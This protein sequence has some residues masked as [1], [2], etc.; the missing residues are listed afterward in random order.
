MQAIDLG[1]RTPF[2]PYGFGCIGIDPNPPR[3]GEP[4]TIDMPLSNSTPEP[5]GVE[6]IEVR[7]APFGIGV[8]WQDIATL[9]PLTL[10]PD[11]AHIEHA[12]ATWTPDEPG[13]RCVRA[14]IHVAGK[15]HPQVVGRNLDIVRAGAHEDT[16]S[17]PF[18]LGNP[19]RERVPMMLRLVNAPTLAGHVRVGGRIL[20]V[21]DP[22]WLQPG[23]VVA[24]EVRLRAR[25]Q[26]GFE[27]DWRLEGSIGAE[28]IDG[29]IVRVQ[30]AAAVSSGSHARRPSAP[31]AV[32][33]YA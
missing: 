33:A 19:T 25:T 21:D 31:L 16:W 17:V 10:L 8:P 18:H 13:H 5:I 28:L 1:R 29:L 30:R 26:E 2:S 27:A 14:S 4:L 22:V 3:V 32:L 11:P 20:P 15:E 12:T 24:A 23:E 6:R 9:G 7:L